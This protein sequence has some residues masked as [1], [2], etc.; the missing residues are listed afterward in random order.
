MPEKYCP[1]CG[2]PI[3]EEETFCKDCCENASKRSFLDILSDNTTT[4]REEEENLPPPETEI[5]QA[6]NP[7]EEEAEKKSAK[8][9]NR[10]YITLAVAVVALFLV[11][12]S[13]FYF[14][15]KQEREK[16]QVEL[17]YWF[18][19]IEK[20]TPNG[21]SEYLI[22]YPNGYFRE[23][24]QNKITELRDAEYKRWEKVKKSSD[25]ND[26]Y[27][28]I[29]DYPDTPF[30]NEIS[31]TMDSL[32]WIIA[33]KNNT[34]EAYLA[35]I[36]SSQLGNI[37]GYYRTIAQERY[38]YLK[39]TKE[40]EGEELKALKTTVSNLFQ[41]LSKQQYSVL[42][43]LFNTVIYNFY[44]EKSLPAATIIKSIQ[45]DAKNNKIISLK[46]TPN[47]NTF[48]ALRNPDSIYLINIV[49]DKEVK[50][51]AKKTNTQTS[52]EKLRIELNSKMKM[53]SMYIQDKQ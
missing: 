1:L 12:G 14:I 46:Y 35:Y 13:V 16:K 3:S 42:P 31:R 28:F 6:E 18:S 43:D 27:L 25:L 45:N 49:V 38:D 32:S 47:F 30:K 52:K 21:Y 7:Q 33:E 29:R 39:N 53:Q 2:K 20:N 11:G 36:E 17:N 44:G 41:T 37:S 19:C 15:N 50:T 48:T 10:K 8:P 5:N 4:F 22:S 34:K 51:K 23:E 26:Y 24:A 40:V 9:I